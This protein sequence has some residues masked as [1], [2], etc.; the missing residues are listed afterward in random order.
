MAT[1]RTYWK[2][3]D[4]GKTAEPR[5]K[6]AR[7][8]GF[9][10][11]I[12]K[13]DA[14]RLHYDLRLELDGV[15][16]SWAVTRGP[17]LV[18]GDKRLAIHVE[19]HPIEYNTFE[20]T[21]PEDQ[22]GGGTVMVWDRGTWTPE[23]DPHK[24]MQKGHLDFE[25]HG[26]KLKGGW[27]L[28]RMR[29]RPGERQE[30]WLL[31][32]ATDD[33]ARGKSDPD[34]LEE[35]PD[36]AATGRSIEEIA[37]DKKKVWHSNQS[38]KANAARLAKTETERKAAKPRARAPRRTSGKRNSKKTAKV[39][40]SRPGRLPAFV[41]PCLATLSANPP[42]NDGWVHEIKFD[43]Y[44]IQARLHEGTVT[45]KTRTGLDW[46]AKFQAIAEACAALADH[47][48]IL[49]GEIASVDEAGRSDFSALQD[50]LKGGRQDRMV[51]YVFDLL[52]LDGQDLTIVPLLERKRA[53][54]DLLSELPS[55]SIVQMSEHFE[56][57]GEVVLKHANDL[58]LEGIVSKRAD[59]SYRSGRGTDWLKIKTAD[60]QEFVVIGYEPS[61]KGTRLIRSLLLG[62]YD[63][64]KLRYAG[65]IGTGWG[66]KQERE[67]EHRLKAISRKSTPLDKVPEE[68]R[69]ARGV[70]WVE[71][72][73][74]I[75]VEF[76]GWTGGNLV[77][78][79]SL[80]GVRED[81][82]AREVV[83]EVAQMPRNAK[84]AALRQKT[85]TKTGT[86]KAGKGAVQVA[87]V[88]LTHPDRVYWDD[89]KVTKTMLAKYYMQVWDWMRPHVT[90]RVLAL[91]RCPD[92][93]SGQ[94]FFQKHASAGI[95]VEH[96]KLVPDDGDKSI[97]IDNVS[98][99]IS[100]AQAG[101]LEIHIRGSSI[102]HLEE[103][104]RLVF[105][106]DPGPGVAWKELI[107]AARDV[108]KR[109]SEFKLESFVKTTGGKGLH[110]VV[111]I[112]PAPW[113]KAKDFCRSLAEQ[114]STDEP[115]RFIA[116]ARI[117]A[118]KNKIFID[119]LR[120]SREATAIAPYSTRARPGAT[121]SV[122]MTW[123]ELG[124]Q[125]TPN[126]FTVQNIGKRLA[127]LRRDPWEK[128][129]KIKQALPAPPR[130]RGKAS[131]R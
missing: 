70:K 128:V 85:P 49:D 17:S 8:T 60:N 100:L 12:Q 61:D 27:H 51:Y 106:L 83:R 57:D 4:F 119:Y 26:E 110:V 32:K 47:D 23:H 1:L 112:K 104:D 55:K 105:D 20:G 58:H 59:S 29:K 28:V 131:R 25:L 46:T 36:S 2:K 67:L 33:A 11:V 126:A 13:H 21:I 41:E 30:P 6:T 7:K 108:R 54:K 44:R 53:L 56:E 95:D 124:A 125:K 15:M 50:D 65:R 123:E 48:A 80:K 19:D 102:D 22:Y 68:E 127:R 81:K 35:M 99:L 79:G 42:Q 16:M 31:I 94:C 86:A 117:A 9:R 69:L 73:M 90:D 3:R 52:H 122:P 38:A 87:G 111:P 75:E 72:R 63:K 129:G 120:N 71:P 116:V 89:V 45:L 39:A 76:R 121:V 109:M 114:M 84:Q 43:G 82:L 91:V 98:G 115:N 101:V 78:Q 103:A 77:R 118:R 24:G 40:G 113:E 130:D 10:Y 96:L 64:V 92:G 107:D 88:T 97:A 62:Y 74:V 93:A 66:Q 14:T 18:P 37:A 34:V 5:G